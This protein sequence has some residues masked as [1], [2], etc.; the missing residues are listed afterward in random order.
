MTATPGTAAQRTHPPVSV[1]VPFFGR[2]TTGLERLLHSLSAQDYPGAVEFI[3]VDNNAQPFLP[4]AYIGAQRLLVHEPTPGSYAARNAGLSIAGGEIIAFTD[5]DCECAAD[6]ISHGVMA[7]CAA[8]K[9]GIVGGAIQPRPARPEAPRLAERYDGF[10]HMRQQ[11]YV[12][13]MRFAATANCF[14][15]R[16]LFRTVGPFDPQL[17]SGGDRAWCRRAVAAGCG[18]AYAPDAIVLHDAR[19]L[20]GLLLKAR[21]LAGQE[22]SHARAAGGG[23]ARAAR[24][25]LQ[26]YLARVRRLVD[27]GERVGLT[28]RLA[29]LALATSLQA[30]RYAELLRL[31]LTR[32]EP[33]RR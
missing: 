31:S 27:G 10:F 20:A 5:S 24:T 18:L 12:G 6:W 4:V 30:V 2:D 3:V 1:I 13:V 23:P 33:E 16:D 28:D 7:L 17:R 25:E 14:I 8:P 21:R 22:W 32:G 9:T 19:S 11:H 15:R 29:F 26:F